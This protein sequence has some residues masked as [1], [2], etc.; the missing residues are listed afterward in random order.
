MHEEISTMPFDIAKIVG[1]YMASHNW[2][3]AAKRL[4]L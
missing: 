2:E 3:E 4:L 1:E